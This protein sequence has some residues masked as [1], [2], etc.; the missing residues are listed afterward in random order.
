MSSVL[1]GKHPV[2]PNEES[3]RGMVHQSDPLKDPRW[4]RFVDRHP[5][6][7]VF[8]SRAWLE[9]LHKTYGYEVVAYT[10][11]APGEDLDNAIVFCRIESWLTGRRL[12]SLP[13][14][15]HCECLV[16]R[17]QDWDVLSTAL[18][19]EVRCRGWRYVELRPLRDLE[20]ATSLCKTEMSYS[21][22]VLDLRSDL[23]AI[24]QNFHKDSIQRKIRRAER[25]R[26]H[27]EEGS[28]DS[29]LDKFYMLF[30]I[31]RRRHRLPPQPRRWFENL[32]GCFGNA[33]KIR[34]A[35][36][37]RRPVAGMLTLRHKDTLVYK[38]GCSDVRF[39]NLGGVHL[40]FWTSIREAKAAGLKR[41]DFGR[42]D[43]GQSGLT[44]FRRRWGATESVLTY[45]RLAT[46]GRSTHLFDLPASQWK[47]TIP[48]KVLA[49]L[50]GTVLS[51]VGR[52]L[53]K[54][55]G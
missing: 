3:C 28:T 48:N 32:I 19:Q 35:L 52:V 31:T 25:E 14:S 45:S 12:I 33:L 30:A 13:F 53:Y 44:T 21:F 47:T 17:Q 27:Y 24:F 36:N 43:A 51:A 23:E 20:I 37:D 5:R 34:I 38:Y 41:F 49:H 22:H 42:A 7:S 26:L 39:N 15:D 55:I 9:A 11:S 10:T 18:E 1:C 54:H 4:E 2:T 40:L 16:E 8:H 46:S 50:P 29:L 6:A